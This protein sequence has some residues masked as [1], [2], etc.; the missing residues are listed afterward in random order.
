MAAEPNNGAF[1]IPAEDVT[2]TD[3]FKVPGDK[4]GEKPSG[5]LNESQPSYNLDNKQKQYAKQYYI[6][7]WNDWDVDVKVRIRGSRF[8]DEEMSKSVIDQER[9]EIKAGKGCGFESDTGHSYLE[10]EVLGLTEPPT[11]GKLEITV[12]QRYR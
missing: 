5:E 10:V 7:I 4:T 9:T 11:E 1:W 8:N 12:Q 3:S 6:H 2:T